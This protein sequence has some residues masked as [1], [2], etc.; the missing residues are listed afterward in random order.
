MLNCSIIY[1]PY[2]N[3]EVPGLLELLGEQSIDSSWGKKKTGL[4]SL[5]I[6]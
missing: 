2:L 1:M 4:T 5:Q 3:T 6:P